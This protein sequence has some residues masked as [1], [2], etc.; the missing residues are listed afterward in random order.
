VARARVAHLDS[1]VRNAH[2]ADFQAV[3]DF[4]LERSHFDL[5]D[6]FALRAFVLKRRVVDCSNQTS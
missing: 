1:V 6:E 2:L 4:V 3:I 5:A